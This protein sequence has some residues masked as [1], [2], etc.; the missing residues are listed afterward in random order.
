MDGSCRQLKKTV[1]AADTS[2][3]VAR[4]VRGAVQKE[5]R[6]GRL[7]RDLHELSAEAG[8]LAAGSAQLSGG[9]HDGAGK[10]PT[11]TSS[12]ATPVRA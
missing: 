7:S 4:H 8:K 1:D 12:N 11:T 9:L 5:H 3:D 2:A 6:L 10:I